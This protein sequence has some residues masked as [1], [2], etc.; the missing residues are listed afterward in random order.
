VVP[1]HFAIEQ[2][3]IGPLVRLLERSPAKNFDEGGNLQN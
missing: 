1:F 3:G 2:I